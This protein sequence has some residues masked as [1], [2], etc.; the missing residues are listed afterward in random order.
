MATTKS[1][2]DGNHPGSHYLVVEDPKSPSTWHLR[3]KDASGKVDPRLLGAA[4]AALHEGYRG[5]KYEGPGKEEAI[6]KLRRLYKA[7]G[8][9]PP[10]EGKTE[11]AYLEAAGLL[12]IV[13]RAGA[14]HSSQDTAL[15]QQMHDMA[16]TLGAKCPDQEMPGHPMLKAE[17]GPPSRLVRRR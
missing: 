8:M 1:E 16:C 2:Q 3:V 9:T 7:E 5:N 4:W 11:K 6:A 12:A 14:R 17:A 13:Q 10:G 15:I